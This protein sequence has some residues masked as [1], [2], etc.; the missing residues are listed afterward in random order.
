MSL[1]RSIFYS[2]CSL[3]GFVDYRSRDLV[4]KALG[5]VVLL[6]LYPLLGHLGV[7]VNVQ[8]PPHLA[9]LLV[10]MRGLFAILPNLT[11]G[12]ITHHGDVTGR[13]MVDADP[14]F[15]RSKRHLIDG[16]CNECE[17]FVQFDLVY[18]LEER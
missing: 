17:L 14:L 4:V 13:V 5:H 9:V 1:S 12:G 7:A 10:D 3:S 8:M 11:S 16:Y 15:N 6:V 18:L 2:A